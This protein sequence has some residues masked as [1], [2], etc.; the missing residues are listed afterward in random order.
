VSDA[1]VADTVVVAAGK[2]ERDD[3][4]DGWQLVVDKI[5]SVS[6]SLHS[7]ASANKPL[8]PLE[9]SFCRCSACLTALG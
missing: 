5:E 1:L 7:E 8:C 3:Y 6:Y 2:I 4:R 9:W